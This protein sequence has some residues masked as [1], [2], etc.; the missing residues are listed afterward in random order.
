MRLEDSG[1]TYVYAIDMAKSRQKK[2]NTHLAR[3]DL[4]SRSESDGSL[5]ALPDAETARL[6]GNSRL[7]IRAIESRSLLA[8]LVQTSA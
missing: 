7:T 3:E 5:R 6:Y 4:I 1:R 2:H 8:S